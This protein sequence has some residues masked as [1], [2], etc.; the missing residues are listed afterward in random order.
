QEKC[1]FRLGGGHQGRGHRRE[2][3]LPSRG[4]PAHRR[5]SRSASSG[6]SWFLLHFRVDVVGA[7][8]YR[9]LND[10][11]ELVTVDLQGQGIGPLPS[12]LSLMLSQQVCM[13]VQDVPGPLLGRRLIP[14][15]AIL[16]RP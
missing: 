10:G 3:C 7:E 15:D 9:R 4:T 13:A 12:E 6:T 2:R 11:W 14:G 16:R 1:P 5:Q 8:L